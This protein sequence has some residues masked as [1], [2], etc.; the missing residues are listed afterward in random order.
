MF[1]PPAGSALIQLVGRGSSFEVA[2]VAHGG[3]ERIAKR[4]SAS[5]A[6]PAG[7]AAIARERAALGALS[8]AGVPALFD[9]GEDEAGSF[10]IESIV[11]GV[12]LR[13]CLEPERALSWPVRAGLAASVVA[14]T[15]QL[16]DASG[17]DG[18]PLELVHADLGPDAFLVLKNGDVVAIDFGAAG[19]RTP[20]GRLD[21]VGRGTLPY[22]APELCRGESPPSQATDRYGAVL[23]ATEIL[24]GRRFARAASGAAQLAEIGERGHDLRALL[25]AEP[26]LPARA[27]ALLLEHVRFEPSARPTRLDELAAVLCRQP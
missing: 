10:V 18:A 17:A 5:L 21:P 8:G 9:A 15:Q 13:E 24:T 23:L 19:L 27:R 14:L 12:A 7:D 16:H 25:D 20:H 6:A 4:P 2:I 3:Q 22:V 1:R 26:A 11:R